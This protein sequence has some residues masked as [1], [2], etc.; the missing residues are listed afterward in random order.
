MSDISPETI[1]ELVKRYGE[2]AP[3]T[4]RICGAAMAL[5]E[6]GV[7]RAKWH[8]DGE[9]ARWMGMEPGPE[10][11]AREQHFAASETVVACGDRRVIELLDAYLEIQLSTVAAVNLLGEV[12]RQLPDDWSIELRITNDEADLTLTNPDGDDV[13]VHSD[14]SCHFRAA[15]NTALRAESLESGD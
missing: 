2:K 9:Q 7:G 10:K 15:I 4:C 5:G 1:G 12:A 13:E 8:C 3:P 14:G 11:Q 6:V